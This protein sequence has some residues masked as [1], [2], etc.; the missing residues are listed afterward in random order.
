MRKVIEAVIDEK[1]ESLNYA[2][3]CKKYGFSVPKSGKK[4]SINNGIVNITFVEKPF[5]YFISMLGGYQNSIDRV[6]KMRDSLERV[7][8][9]LNEIKDLISREVK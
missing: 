8:N 1:K 9:L 6:S 7:E 3:I 5:S 2:P 4:M